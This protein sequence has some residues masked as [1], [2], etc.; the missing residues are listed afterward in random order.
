MNLRTSV[1]ARLLVMGL[2]LIGLL[3]PLTMV[4]AVVSERATRRDLVAEEVSGTWGG[5]QTIAGP[6]LI[7]QGTTQDLRRCSASLRHRPGELPTTALNV[8][9]NAAWSAKPASRATSESGRWESVNSSFDLSTR[10]RMR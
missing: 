9:L 5:A 6:G 10:C 8:R 2:I 3:I 4:Q 1:I 7:A